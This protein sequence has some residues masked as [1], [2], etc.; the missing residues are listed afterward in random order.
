MCA[1]C[2]SQPSSSSSESRP[3]EP[4]ERYL[5]RVVPI[6]LMFCL[7]LALVDAAV[8]IPLRAKPLASCPPCPSHSA[9]RSHPRTINH[10]VAPLRPALPLAARR[11]RAAARRA[12]WSA[13]GR[14][15][16]GPRGGA[17][18]VVGSSYAFVRATHGATGCRVTYGNKMSGWMRAPFLPP[19]PDEIK[20]EEQQRPSIEPRPT[21]IL[22][23]HEYGTTP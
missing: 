22:A 6:G 10:A 14:A 4:T 8:R 9:L 20:S 2:V 18:A 5:F 1:S 19:D 21:N 11:V 13:R 23:V 12:R 16:A 7:P 15:R 17:R 3:G